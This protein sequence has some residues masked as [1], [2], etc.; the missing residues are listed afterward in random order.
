M[1]VNMNSILLVIVIA[2]LVFLIMRPHPRTLTGRFQP[3][4]DSNGFLAL[5]TETGKVCGNEPG[6][7]RGIRPVASCT[8]LAKE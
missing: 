3:I 5:D 6:V 1:K 7:R 2:L 4:A 8:D